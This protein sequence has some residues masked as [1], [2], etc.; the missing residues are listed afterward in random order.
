MN[1]NPIII[2]KQNES[3]RSKAENSRIE[4]EIRLK[5]A[6]IGESELTENAHFYDT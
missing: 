4:K 3:A 6:V 1:I 5:T 2:R